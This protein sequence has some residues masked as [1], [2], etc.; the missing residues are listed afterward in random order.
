M[1]IR[2]YPSRLT[3]TIR[4]IPSKSDAHRALIAAALADRPTEIVFPQ[5]NDDIEATVR[6]L[7]AL[8]A[9]I[10][11]LERG[12]RIHPIQTPPTSAQLDCGESGST[13][14]FL[15]PIASALGVTATFTGTGRLPN[16]PILELKTEMERHGV[17]FTADR[18]PLTVS[19][20]LQGGAFALP[21]NISSQYITGLLLALPRICG[22]V[23]LTTKAESQSYIDLTLRVMR[24]FGVSTECTESGYRVGRQAYRS[25]ITYTIEGDWSNA[26]FYLAAGALQGPVTVQGLRLDSV[27]G[28]RKVLS[29]LQTFGASVEGLGET[30]RVAGTL[31]NPQT[32]AMQDIPDLLPILA[33]AAAGSTGESRFTHAERLRLKESD[34][35][36]TTEQLLQALG[37]MAKMTSDGL[38]VSGGK[39]TG[40]TVDGANDHR[41]VM[42]AAIA[43]ANADGPVTILGCEAVNKSYPTFFEEFRRLGG[44]FDVL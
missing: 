11:R 6:C 3:G 24:S 28:D 12:I 10:E 8:G 26:A 36:K 16:R 20:T 2:I 17:T 37:I 38:I 34:R 7:E 31:Q 23:T 25:P 42:A 44:K 15:L 18:L 22:S 43:A 14:R 32:V 29:V 5:T 9:T 33:V 39:F 13:L 4:A 40:G 35:L 41:I 21:G 1:D 27:Q 19:G 30:V